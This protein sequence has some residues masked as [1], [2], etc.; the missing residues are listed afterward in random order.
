MPGVASLVW[1]QFVEGMA[2]ASEIGRGMAMAGLDVRNVWL[3][4]VI[5][6]FVFSGLTTLFFE[7]TSTAR[8]LLRFM[9][10]YATRAPLC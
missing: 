7:V 2:T 1:L 6:L 8:H 4:I 5:I 3:R 9:L 10:C